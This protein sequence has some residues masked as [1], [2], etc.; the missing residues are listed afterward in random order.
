MDDS[1]LFQ[2]LQDNQQDPQPTAVATIVSIDGPAY[3]GLGT[4]IAIRANAPVYGTISAGCLENDVRRHAELCF[5]DQRVHRVT[6]DATNDDELIW[7]MGTGCG[8]RIEIQITPLF[9]PAQTALLSWIEA[10][11]QRRASGAFLQE[12]V[13]DGAEAAGLCWLD[14]KGVT[15]AFPTSSLPS[16]AVIDMAMA[17]LDRDGS[18]RRGRRPALLEEPSA[19]WLFR[20]A[21]PPPAVLLVGAGSDVAPLITGFAGLGWQVEVIDHRPDQRDPNRYPA[22]T[23]LTAERAKD[24]AARPAHRRDF[25]A[26]VIKGHHFERDAA[27]L[28]AVLKEAIPYVGV[29]GPRSRFE[30]LV[31]HLAEQGTR[32][33]AEQCA[34]VY[35]PTGLDLGGENPAEVALSVVAE[36]MKETHRRTGAP[37]RE[38]KG[39]IHERGSH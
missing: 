26:A 3:R 32:F 23:W 28:A 2:A 24:F 29:L 8:G 35:A 18:D 27:W 12:I 39:P 19:R 11:Q 14:G 9:D 1:A 25:A 36:V 31:A 20:P 17:R 4:Q 34:R 30:R 21:A 13:A 22:A 6:Y 5:Q 37:L 10:V 33:D 7:G 15:P 16:A 38:K